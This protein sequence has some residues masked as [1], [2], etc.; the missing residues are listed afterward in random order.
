MG[1]RGGGQLGQ[2]KREN[3][4]KCGGVNDGMKMLDRIDF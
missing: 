1:G 2:K 3:R 4:H